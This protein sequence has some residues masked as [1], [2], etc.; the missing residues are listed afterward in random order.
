MIEK[1]KDATRKKLNALDSDPSYESFKT[2]VDSLMAARKLFVVDLELLKGMESS[3]LDGKV[4]RYLAPG[5]AIFELVDD[6]LLPIKPI[7]IQLSQGETAT[8]IFTPEDG[9]NWRIAKACFAASD[10]II[11]ELVSHLGN[12][13]L[14][15]EGP[16]VAMHRQLP[17]EH[18]IHALLEPHVE[19]TAFINWG[20]Q[21][22]LMVKGGGVD[23]LQANKIEDS[24]A[25]VLEQVQAR[26][27]KDFSPEVDIKDRRVMKEDF[28]G[29]YPYRDSGLKYWEATHTWVKDYLDLY[30]KNDE[31]I[32]GDYELQ[33]FVEEMINLGKMKW[34]EELASSKDKKGLIAKVLANLIYSAST[35]HAA[36]NFPQRPEMSFSPNTPGSVYAA[37]PTDKDE[38]TFEDY[39]AYLPP[40][41]IATTQ[42]VVGNI[43]GSIY[44][45]K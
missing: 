28:P 14:V 31:D 16:M 7:G 29:R 1:C 12:T 42:V 22:L 15:L 10:C 8:P 5:V 13:H 24:W 36:V 23:R 27:S 26:I 41:G 44:H 9:F 35:L 19:G 20:A 17:K 40:I 38:R 6:E 11:H 18:P 32:S 30:Y 3:P 33:A 34:L 25:L 43:L 4:V 2:K 45:T 37:P 21:E 39:L